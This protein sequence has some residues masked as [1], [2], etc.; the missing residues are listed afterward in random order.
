MIV[1]LILVSCLAAIALALTR[2][3]EARDAGLKD[4]DDLEFTA[5]AI[6]QLMSRK[7]QRYL[8]DNLSAGEFRS[9]HRKRM[10]LVQG[11]ASGLQYALQRSVIYDGET[12]ALAVE[13][14][15]LLTRLRMLA[16]FSYAWPT[17]PVAS[18]GLTEKW[19]SLAP[20]MRRSFSEPFI[21]H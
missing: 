16:L 11:Y 3:L 8:M 15:A 21:V 5:Q 12:A 14:Q 17:L 18:S 7:E 4:W 1:L 10:R 2:V 20:N 19:S 13:L 9:F 6:A